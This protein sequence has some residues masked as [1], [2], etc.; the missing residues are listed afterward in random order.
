MQLM[1]VRTLDCVR[2]N[3]SVL[4]LGNFITNAIVH[5]NHGRPNG[6][7]PTVRP[8]VRLLSSTWQPCLYGGYNP[9]TNL[10]ELVEQYLQK[11]SYSLQCLFQAFIIHSVDIFTKLHWFCQCL[12]IFHVQD[13]DVEKFITHNLPFA[14]INEAFKLLLAGECLRTVL[15]FNDST[16]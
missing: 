3:A 7:R 14:L 12:I 6:H 10:L 11:V 8:S 9:K 15:H 5:P 4:P 13:L 1:S 2:T 16:C